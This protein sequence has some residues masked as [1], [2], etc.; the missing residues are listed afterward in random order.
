MYK[1]RLVFFIALT[2]LFARV[3]ATDLKSSTEPTGQLAI[4]P[5]FREADI[6]RDPN[7]GPQYPNYTV[8][9]YRITINVYL[10]N[11]SSSTLK[12]PTTIS[13]RGGTSYRSAETGEKQFTID[14]SC[15]I[16]KAGG[17]PLSRSISIVPSAASLL[18]VELKPREFGMITIWADVPSE[19]DPSSI[20]FSFHIDEAI[21]KRFATWSGRVSH[22]LLKES[23][24]LQDELADRADQ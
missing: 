18:L 15:L 12:V 24:L 7:A 16:K 13:T 3:A 10:Y 23:K 2:T 17:N 8:K 19:V 14:Y 4:F 5:I 9:E 21:G 11:Q 1:T 6:V 20:E 22:K